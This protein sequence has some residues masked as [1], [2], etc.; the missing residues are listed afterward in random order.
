M[1][2]EL[3]CS[4]LARMPDLHD[5][6]KVPSLIPRHY[7][8]NSNLQFQGPYDCS[9][10]VLPPESC[11]G[12]K[13]EKEEKGCWPDGQDRGQSLCQGRGRGHE[14]KASLGHHPDGCQWG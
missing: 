13:E 8:W 2:I 1:V 11:S 9:Q 12:A 5:H 7:S 4:S 14:G 6:L 3:R 10:T